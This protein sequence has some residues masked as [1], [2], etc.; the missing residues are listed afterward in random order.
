MSLGLKQAMGDP[1][2]EVAR[3]FAP[4]WVVEGPVISLTKFGAFVQLSEGVEGMIHIGD[5]SADR[6]LN[7]PQEMLK[8]GQIVKAQVLEVDTERRRLRLGMKQ[9]VP[10]SLDEYLAE[11]KV[12]DLVAGRLTEV[13]GENGRVELGEGIE[14]RCRLP[15]Q[16]ASEENAAASRGKADLSSLTSML[17]ARWKG[18]ASAGPAKP[19][20]VREGQIRN[21]RI[22]SLDTGAKTIHLELV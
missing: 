13:S 5:M 8:V 18:A 2:A 10:T 14:G 6:R 3:N 16:A 7:H 19:E 21:F 1:W 11:H 17:Q 9:L 15:V 4:G 12:G 22:T 20:A